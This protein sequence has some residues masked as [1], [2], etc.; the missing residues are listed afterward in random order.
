DFQ[1]T[2]A[3]KSDPCSRYYSP[4]DFDVV[5]ACLHA[6]TE[7]WEFSFALPGGLD[8]HAKCAGK[9]SSNVSIDE[10]WSRDP[11]RVLRAATELK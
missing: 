9:L 4:Q 11:L 7:R 5:A 2:R 10:R 6:V 8:P 3:A 1:R